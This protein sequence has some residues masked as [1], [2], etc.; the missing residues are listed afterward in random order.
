MQVHV[1]DPMAYTRPYD[2]ALCEALGIEGA[3]VELFTSRFAY[4]STPQPQHYELR[5]LFYRRSTGTAGSGLRRIT[6]LVSH[7]PDMLRYRRLAAGADVVHFQWLAVQWLDIHLLPAKPLVLTAHDLLPREPRPGQARAQ[8]RLYDAVDA[9]VVH[10]EQA[11]RTMVDELALDADRVHTIHHGA[12]THLTTQSDEQPL[13]AE[14]AQV[15]VPVVLFFG[16]LRPYKGIEVLLEAWRGI[17]EAEL[18]IVGRPRMST[19]ELKAA[20][21]PSVRFIERFISDQ[22]L[23]AYFRRADLVVL[24]YLDTRRFDQS[25]VLATAL[26]FAKPMIVTDVGGFAE[27]AQAGAARLVPPGDPVALG[28]AIR[29]LL[30]NETERARLANAARSLAAGAYSWSEAA[31]RTLSLYAALAG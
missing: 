20:A 18:W 6:K 17:S 7:V 29:K 10:S 23:P 21:P 11:R 22:E 8:R 28:Q 15:E 3:N 5:E 4:G 12:F 26:A 30:Q 31:R 1:V 13:P 24:P 9:V 19:G 16:L 27:I 14:L 25:G 2:H